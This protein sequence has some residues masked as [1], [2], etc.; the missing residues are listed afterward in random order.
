MLNRRRECKCILKFVWSISVLMCM[1]TNSSYAAETSYIGDRLKQEAAKS[2]TVERLS[3]TDPA[4]AISDAVKSATQ[5]VLESEGNKEISETV[6]SSI[7]AE[8]KA[9]L[10]YLKQ[11]I[12]DN[13]K[14]QTIKQTV[15]LTGFHAELD[16]WGKKA[17]IANWPVN[18][19][20][21]DPAKIV[22]DGRISIKSLEQWVTES[23][24]GVGSNERL[25]IKG[26]ITEYL[27]SNPPA[28]DGVEAIK[29]RV[30]E[31]VVS[32]VDQQWSKQGTTIPSIEENYYRFYIGRAYAENS[33]GTWGSDTEWSF[34]ARSIWGKHCLTYKKDC[35]VRAYSRFGK[36][37]SGHLADETNNS[38]SISSSSGRTYIDLGLDLLPVDSAKNGGFKPGLR[39]GVGATNLADT[40]TTV[41]TYYKKGYIG[42]II[43]TV[44]GKEGYAD[45]FL[46]YSYDNAWKAKTYNPNRIIL[47]GQLN[48]P[49][50]KIGK[51]T[52]GLLRLVVNMPTRGS[53]PTDV[54][55]SFLLRV[56]I[57]KFIE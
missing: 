38:Q 39:I 36:T 24:P 20:D 34:E 26:K 9:R 16:E 54:S 15:W 8:A 13:K 7:A 42:F 10:G 19:P 12:A 55:L 14:L 37:M 25:T 29:Q 21:V 41:N 46:G 50:I 48:I 27:E 40:E 1:F 31:D 30:T 57:E 33:D 18:L 23:T 11:W 47:D 4:V 53:D 43:P 49:A 5:K 52:D 32:V 45:L 2:I 17:K 35:R 6:S 51:S 28:V 22:V 44:Y 3:G 56:D